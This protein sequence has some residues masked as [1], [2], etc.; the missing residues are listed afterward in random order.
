LAAS[1]G[2][3]RAA[4]LATR[5]RR[6]ATPSPAGLASKK[7]TKIKQFDRDYKVFGGSFPDLGICISG[8]AQQDA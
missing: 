3:P 5:S 4:I 6:A 1:A 8:R 7:S 2:T